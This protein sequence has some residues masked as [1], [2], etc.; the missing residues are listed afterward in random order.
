MITD[1]QTSKRPVIETTEK[2]IQI[3]ELSLKVPVNAEWFEDTEYEDSY[4]INLEPEREFGPLVG[5][6]FSFVELL[7][8]EGEAYRYESDYLEFDGWDYISYDEEF[9][10]TDRIIDLKITD[11]YD[12]YGNMIYIFFVCS[13]DEYEDWEDEFVKILDSVRIIE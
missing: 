4:Y 8:E 6:D 12:S 10:L 1:T 13:E 3:G 5:I 7:S 2:T 11:Q 9:D